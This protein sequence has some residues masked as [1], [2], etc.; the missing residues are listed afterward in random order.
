M[1]LQEGYEEAKLKA[2]SLKKDAN[3]QYRKA[4]FN[5]T[6]ALFEVAAN[7]EPKLSSILQHSKIPQTLIQSTLRGRIDRFNTPIIPDYT[8]LNTKVIIKQLK[9]MSTW[10]LLKVDRTERLNKN[11]KTIFQA[12]NREHQ[13]YLNV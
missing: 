4:Q 11:R 9:G 3:L 1:R 13:R 7:T 12:V 8:A 10:N 2:S 6:K 5:G